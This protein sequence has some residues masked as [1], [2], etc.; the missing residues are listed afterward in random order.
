MR[1]LFYVYLRIVKVQMSNGFEFENFLSTNYRKFALESDSNKNFSNT[2]TT[3]GFWR[4]T[5]IYSNSV[6]V[7]NLL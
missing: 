5:W 2:Y 1:A 7:A 4:R 3:W 6:K